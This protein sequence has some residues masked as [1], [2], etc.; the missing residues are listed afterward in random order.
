MEAKPEINTQYLKNNT[1]FS[2]QPKGQEENLEFGKCNYF[3][4]R[5]NAASPNYIVQTYSV[6]NMQ[7]VVNK[8][9]LPEGGDITQLRGPGVSVNYVID[10]DGTIFQ[11]VPD[12]KK[13]WAAGAGSLITGSKL[14]PI[15]PAMKNTMND[16]SISI[17]NI[18]NGKESLTAPQQEA[19]IALTS[20][21]VSEHNI[22]PAKVIGL[23]D[24]APGRHIAPGPYFPWETFAG[25][26]LGLW[27]NVER[28][29]NPEVIVSW[30]QGNKH[31]PEDEESLAAD[32][33]E[34]QE[35][36]A[37]ASVASGSAGG[38]ESVVKTYNAETLEAQF[39]KLGMVGF[40]NAPD[41]AQVPSELLSSV[42]L[43]NLHHLGKE[44]LGNEGSN[45]AFEALWTDSSDFDARATLGEWTSNSQAVLDSILDS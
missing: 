24:W 2:L 23:G 31:L 19:N 21:L 6:G 8:M 38:G 1:Q 16:W 4:D 42:L 17:M 45:N 30:K 41:P 12:D 11:M 15:I 3:N 43:F 32:L 5:G 33:Q 29:K 13:P 14:N 10:K 44:I 40:K 26:G 9:V 36:L 22:D 25:Q 39:N 34:V 20:Y 37:S 28:D 18:N 27:S 35:K 7:S